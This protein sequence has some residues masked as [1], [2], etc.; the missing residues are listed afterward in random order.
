MSDSYAIRRYHRQTVIPL[1]TN[2]RKKYLMLFL[3]MIL[4][5][6][7]GIVFFAYTSGLL[8]EDNPQIPQQIIARINIVRQANDLPPVQLSQGLTKDAIKISRDV[9]VSPRGY[10]SGTGLKTGE[11]ANIFVI[12]KISW[13]ISGYD[14]QQQMFTTLENDNSLFRKNILDTAFDSVGIGVSGDA[15]NYY[16]VTIWG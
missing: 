2:R 13:A 7:V 9:R 11:A 8:A 15:Y 6:T 12:P 16:I 1:G 3:A 14:S 4:A 10:L 5:A